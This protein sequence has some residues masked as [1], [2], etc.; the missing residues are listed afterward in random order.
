MGTSEF[1]VNDFN[2]QIIEEFRANNGDVGGPFEGAQV[3]LV[4]HVGAKSGTKRVNPLVYHADGDDW[5]IFASNNGAP[6]NPAWYHNLIANPET[7]IEVRD[8]TIA[9]TATELAGA[10][11]TRVWTAQRALVPQFAEY[12][13]STDRTIPVI[14]MRR[15]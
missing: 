15:R 11:R 2:R 5:V 10:E 4:H 1:D 3:I 6:N 9:V 7:T 12:E 13:A 14:S 8:D